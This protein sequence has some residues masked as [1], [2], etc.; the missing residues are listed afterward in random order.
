MPLYC[1][2]LCKAV[3][4][5]AVSERFLS[6]D[7]RAAQAEGQLILQHALQSLSSL[8][9]ADRPAEDADDDDS[10]FDASDVRSGLSSFSLRGGGGLISGLS[11]EAGFV[12]GKVP[13]LGALTLELP[14][15]NLLFD[16]MHLTPVDLDDCIQGVGCSYRG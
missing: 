9:S 14:A 10:Q 12:P 4:G 6:P 5:R 11:L 3:C 8:Y 1:L 15:C 13:D 7:G 2:D 16:G